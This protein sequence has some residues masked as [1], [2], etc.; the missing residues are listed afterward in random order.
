MISSIHVID[1]HAYYG[2]YLRVENLKLTNVSCAGRALLSKSNAPNVRV[3]HH[4]TDA[5]RTHGEFL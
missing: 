4:E 3:F 2:D 1:V 5:D